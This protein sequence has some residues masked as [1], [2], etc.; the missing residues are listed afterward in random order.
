MF[1][2]VYLTKEEQQELEELRKRQSITWIRGE[3]DDLEVLEE[4]FTLRARMVTGNPNIK[5]KI[6][7]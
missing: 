6:N 5:A 4:F 1:G 7:L 3:K 2:L